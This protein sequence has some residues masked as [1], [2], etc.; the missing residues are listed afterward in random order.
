MVD[1]NALADEVVK[2]LKETNHAN[3]RVAVMIVGPPGSGKSTVATE[4]C[5]ELNKRFSLYLQTNQLS[6]PELKD[7]GQP[8]DLTSTI[9]E[10]SPELREELQRDAGIFK[11]SVEN[12]DF[13]PVKKVL[14]NS[15]VEIIGRGGQ[16]NAFTIANHRL[17]KCHDISIA[18]TIPMDGFH[19]SRRCLDC[20]K[21]PTQ[22]HL[23]RG[24]PPTFDS[25]NFLQLCKVLARTCTVTPPAC[26][27]S[28]C[29]EF[30]SKTFLSNMPTITIPGFDHKMKDPTPNQYSIDPYTRVLVFE[31]LYLL[32]DN[33]NWRSIH[34]TLLDTGALLVWNVD[35]EEGVIAERVAKRHLEAGLVTTLDD[36]MQRFQ[37]NDLINARLI[38]K[39]LIKDGKIVNIRND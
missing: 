21:D 2:L 5:Q 17:S 12:V 1:I 35:I 13:K 15:K 9:D 19:L 7:S 27:S 39:H 30:M 25:N 3:Y 38:K 8:I 34:K 10:I 22:A 6:G 14:G 28:S 23:R 16:A 4:L 31:G 29:F 36:G 26:P 37:L 33:A 32:Y 18:Q 11:D 24:S 20:F